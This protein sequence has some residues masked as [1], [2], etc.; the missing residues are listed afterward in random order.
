MTKV[1]SILP[2]KPLKSKNILEG[3][4]MVFFGFLA[5]YPLFFVLL[6]SLK[7]N[8]DVIMN[9]FGIRTF[10]PLNYITAWTVGKVGEYLLNSVITTIITI[11]LQLLVIIFASYAFGKLRPWGSSVLF[12]ITLI[13]MFVTSEMTTVPNYMTIKNLG[14]MQTRWSLILPYTAGGLI[15]GTYILTNFIRAL[16]RELDEA[17]LIDGAGIWDIIVRVDLPLIV[18]AL[19]ALVIYNFNGVWSE[20]YWALI[21]VKQDHLKTLP[22]GLIN[23]QSQ[24]TSSYGVLTAGLMILMTPVITVYLFFSKYFI[25]GISAG[26]IKG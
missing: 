6:T 17:A 13:G 18:P 16:P 7:S 1:K 8:T 19:A 23:F 4:V 22:L 24:F 25:A 20:F 21:V 14:L 26:A 3:A 9:P 2:I 12:A 15:M 5:L 10:E 11:A